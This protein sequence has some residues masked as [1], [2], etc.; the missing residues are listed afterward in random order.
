MDIKKGSWRLTSTAYGKQ[1]S[2]TVSNDQYTYLVLTFVEDYFN[3][4]E[5]KVIEDLIK[6]MDQDN[7]LI[8]KAIVDNKVQ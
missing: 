1:R 4:K 7:Y 2:Y 3:D 5:L 8:A 6:T